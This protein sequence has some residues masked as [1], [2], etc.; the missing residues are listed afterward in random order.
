MIRHAFTDINDPNF[1]TLY[2]TAF[3]TSSNNRTSSK[4]FCERSPWKRHASRRN[5]PVRNGRIFPTKFFPPGHSGEN[6]ERL[7]RKGRIAATSS[8]FRIS[9]KRREPEREREKET[10][11][12]VYDRSTFE[13]WIQVQVECVAMKIHSR[14][15]GS[16]LVDVVVVVWRQIAIFH[17]I[18]DTKKTKR[19]GER[20]TAIFR[21]KFW[22]SST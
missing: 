2:F 9:N 3:R 5:S 18:S 6:C 7:K 8:A 13:Y 11:S 22:L 15:L 14:G 1:R 12:L 16:P 20:A 4:S 17:S 19:D 21:V 10:L